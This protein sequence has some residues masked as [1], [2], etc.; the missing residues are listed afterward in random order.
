MRVSKSIA[1]AVVVVVLTA[2]A[3]CASHK[4][5]QPA[6]A[7]RYRRAAIREVSEEQLKTD[8][9]LIDALTLQETGHSDE[10]LEAYAQLTR[11]VPSTAAAWYG[12]SLLLIQRGWSDSALHCAQRAVQ[13]QGDNVWYL[14][15]LA[16][17][18]EISGDVSG[19]VATL[20]RVES[21]KGVTENISLHKQHLWESVGQRDKAQKEIEV[22]AD[23]MPQ[24]PHYHAVLAEMNMQRKNYKRAKQYYDQLVEGRYAD[25]VDAHYQPDSIP[26][27]YREQLVANARMF[28]GQQQ[29]EHRG[30]KEVRI[31]HA[32]ADTASHQASVF[33]VLC[34][35]DST[36][37]EVLVPMVERRGTWLLR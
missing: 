14:L 21:L 36:S 8:G 4:S 6:A 31:A 37:E 19:A 12:Q 11:D 32:M 20:N 5:I 25:F 22:L 23:A 2:L 34:Y 17:C 33:L 15:T 7:D 27:S 24:E 28:M 10:A 26:A 16:Q 30:I 1:W 3:G 9:R 35:G 18:Q 29:A 13:L